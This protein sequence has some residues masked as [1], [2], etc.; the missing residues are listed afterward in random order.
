MRSYHIDAEYSRL[1]SSSLDGTLGVFNVDVLNLE[2]GLTRI[3]EFRGHLDCVL[4]MEVFTYNMTGSLDSPFVVSGGKDFCMIVWDPE[5]G[6]TIFKTQNRNVSSI[7]A[8]AVTPSFYP[9]TSDSSITRTDAMRSIDGPDNDVA[10]TEI[11]LISSVHEKSFTLVAEDEQS[12]QTETSKS[13]HRSEEKYRKVLPDLPY[14]DTLGRP[15]NPP[16]NLN[17]NGAVKLAKVDMLPLIATGDDAG[18]I[19]LWLSG[20]LYRI[21]KF[22]KS[23]IRSISFMTTGLSDPDDVLHL[24]SGCSQG[25]FIISNPATGQILHNIDCRLGGIEYLLGVRYPS[26][27]NAQLVYVAG[28]DCSLKLFDAK[29]GRLLSVIVDG[30]DES[31]APFHS[32][33]CFLMTKIMSGC[34]DEFKNGGDSVLDHDD[35]IVDHLII[36]ACRAD[37]GLQ[38]FDIDSVISYWLRP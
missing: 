24:V 7:K 26:M 5:S 32:T 30:E 14:I 33:K 36:T 21:L 10:H 27:N 8:L 25:L 23:S 19:N 2:K 38:C 15:S 37:I 1:I 34:D 31:Q 16:T 17:E 18:N 3:L 13:T 4:T 35:S 29:L 28:N 22:H 12:V 11:S 6:E 20:S 9:S